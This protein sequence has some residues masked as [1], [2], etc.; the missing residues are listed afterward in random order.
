MAVWRHAVDE[1]LRTHHGV[2]GARRLQL[3][4][5]SARTVGRMVERQELFTLLPGV[6]VSAQWPVGRSQRMAAICERNELAVIAFTTAGQEWKHR[7]VADP[8]VHALVPHGSSPVMDGVVVHRCR[9]IDPVDVVTRPDGIRLTSPPR[10][11]FDSADMLGVA[12]TRSVLEQL[13]NEKSCTIDTVIDTYVRLGHP[14]RPGTRTLRAVLAGRPRW[15]QAL[16]SGLE[17]RVLAA[18]EQAGLPAPIPQCPVELADGTVIHLDFGWPAWKVALEVDD[19]AWHEGAL[20]RHRDA[21]RDRK[22]GRQGWYTARISKI[23][24]EG[25]L[26]EALAD[27]ADLLGRRRRAA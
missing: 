20:E 27:V 3:L 4:G 21:R 5:C 8:L 9:R 23:D 11:L 22:A 6:F 12:A 1:W 2:I 16:Q 24:V 17:V 15:Q 7:G 19:P 26:R 10:T 13:L 14:N 25:S 18:I